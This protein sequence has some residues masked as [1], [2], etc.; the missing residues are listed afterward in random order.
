MKIVDKSDYYEKVAEAL[1]YIENNFMEQ[2]TLDAIAKHIHLSPFHFQRIFKEWVGISPKKYLQYTS[3]NYA[4]ALLGK[5]DKSL[6]DA[7][8]SKRPI[9][10]SLK[11]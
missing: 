10:P 5:G 8:F 2:P 9:T 4:K 11:S 1:S 3:S 6:S 7:F